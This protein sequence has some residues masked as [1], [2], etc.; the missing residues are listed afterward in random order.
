LDL[1]ELL[2]NLQKYDNTIKGVRADLAK[3]EARKAGML[4]DIKNGEKAVAESDLAIKQTA[5]EAAK[6]EKEVEFIDSQIKKHGD[7]F[8]LIKNEKELAKYNAE[9]EKLEKDKSAV[10]EK[11]LEAM[12]KTE[13]YQAGLKTLQSDLEKKRKLYAI[14]LADLE[15]LIVNQ[16]EETEKLVKHRTEFAR[17]I[18][19]DKLAVY[20]KL[21]AAKNGVAVAVVSHKVCSGCRLSIS[22]NTLNNAKM[23]QSLVFCPNCQRIIHLES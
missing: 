11:V 19:T 15:K 6:L 7:K 5:I 9:T 1:N 23:V 10:E 17:S 4:A 14:E 18:P 2:F 20:D 13:K 12:D 21:F 16:K 3:M 8:L 22:D